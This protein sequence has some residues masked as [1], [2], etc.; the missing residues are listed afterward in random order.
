M[1]WIEC[2]HPHK[3]HVEIPTPNGTMIG[4]GAFGRRLGHLGGILINRI[5]TLIKET[6]ESSLAPS[7]MQRHRKK[8]ALTRT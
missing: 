3:T 6:P 7:T 5:S 8:W 4:G 1:L 2:L